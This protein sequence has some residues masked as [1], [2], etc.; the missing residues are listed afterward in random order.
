MKSIH[1]L[2]VL[3]F[4]PSIVFA[5]DILFNRLTKLYTK[6]PEKC[7][8]T[9]KRYI[10]YFPNESSS[11]Y[12]ASKVYYDKST[13][14]RN[15]RTEYS[16]LKKA[17]GYAVKFEKA[18]I[19]N[20]GDKLNWEQDKLAIKSSVAKLSNKLLQEDQQSLSASLVIAYSKLDKV[21]K[22]EVLNEDVGINES[23]KT[24][25]SSIRKGFMFGMPSGNE[26]VRSSNVSEEQNLLKMINQER[27]RL[28]MEPLVWEERLAQAARY[29]AFDLGSQ[30]YFDHN[31]YD[32]VNGE[33]VKV[34]GTFTRIGRFYNSSSL[35]SENIAAGSEHADGTYEQWFNSKGHYDN[36]FNK[37]SKKVGIGFYY[38]ENAPFKFYWVFCTAL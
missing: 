23:L 34:G 4:V 30:E 20:L 10:N 17:I 31:T 15:N 22:I 32:R 6:N 18:D 19:E 29:H 5:N 11:Y 37:Q 12:Y 38:D 13:V 28:G 25:P 14:A 3:L 7:L 35:N 21:E 27:K 8:E 36:M 2:F 1:L 24:N 26:N 9:A 16:L 33:L